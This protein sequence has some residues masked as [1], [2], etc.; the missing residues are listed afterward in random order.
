MVRKINF[1]IQAKGGTGKSLYTYL[2]ALA[3]KD[4]SSLFV[5]AD[6]FAKTSS[7][8]LHF[9]PES[10]RTTLVLQSGEQ[11]ESPSLNTFLENL[12]LLPIAGEI[13]IDFGC[14]ES[15]Y[16]LDL[17]LTDPDIAP[18][19][20]ALGLDIH[21]HVIAAG[22]GAYYSC[23]QYFKWV[24]KIVDP[25]MDL[26]VWQ[27][28]GTFRPFPQL[29]YQL[30]QTCEKLDIPLRKFADFEQESYLGTRILNGM[31]NGLD[32]DS[33]ERGPRLR[34]RHELNINFK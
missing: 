33:F 21:F 32:L 30:A 17:M 9:L 4:K 7:H 28:L 16:L 5:D 1:I 26:T 10:R 22:G 23:E 19:C 3:E 6:N 2:R 29:S 15:G 18:V 11:T 12:C 8:Q 27:N 34:L 20:D 13:F 25:W 14:R 24:V 31:I